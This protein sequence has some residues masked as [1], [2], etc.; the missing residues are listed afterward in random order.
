MFTKMILGG[1]AVLAL[2]GAWSVSQLA[3]TAVSAACKSAVGMEL[4]RDELMY[5]ARREVKACEVALDETKANLAVNEKQLLEVNRVRNEFASDAR[6]WGARSETAAQALAQKGDKVVLATVQI[7]REVVKADS[8]R[9]ADMQQRRVQVV[10]RL[11]RAIPAVE[12]SIVD[13]HAAVVRAEAELD[14]ARCELACAVVLREVKVLADRVRQ[15]RG[16]LNDLSGRTKSGTGGLLEQ[17]G[18][19]ADIE[20]VRAYDNAAAGAR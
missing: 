9:F 6:V 12:Q 7:P 16:R 15:L 19:A 5:L 18:I 20:M 8:T 10:E 3:P 14:A 2:G 11:D 17:L 4:S 13:G 1:V